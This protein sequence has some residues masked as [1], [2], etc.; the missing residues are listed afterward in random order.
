MQNKSN[1]KP[2]KTSS[3]YHNPIKLLKTYRDVRWSLKLSMEHHQ[4]DF[5]SEYGM[6]VKEYLDDI[7]AAG[8]EF[9]G[10]K[11]EHHANSIKR[12]A[13]MLKLI[14]KS[15]HLI[16]QCNS[17]G[18]G[19]YWNLYYTY[20][21]AQKL[22]NVDEIVSN[23]QVHLPYI[24]KENYFKHRRKAIKLF[25]TVLWGYTAKDEIDILDVFIKESDGENS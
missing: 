9:L 11:L 2:E 4:E 1:S 12:T 10:T 23:L 21:S 3:V 24:T 19:Y 22:R 15:A 14:D 20:L 8:I 18:E 16:R 7:Y 13:E 5:E 25:A 17:E 6:S